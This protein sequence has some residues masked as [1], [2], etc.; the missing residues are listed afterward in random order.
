MKILRGA[1]PTQ[2]WRTDL[3]EDAF[4]GGR[5]DAVLQYVDGEGYGLLDSFR[6]DEYTK[7]RKLMI[8]SI[9][10]SGGLT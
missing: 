8:Y 6:I 7:N 9:D 5:C 1:S 10:G 4:D 3:V 2:L